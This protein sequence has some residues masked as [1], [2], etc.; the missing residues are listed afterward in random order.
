MPPA[1]GALIIPHRDVLEQGSG[2]VTVVTP[3]FLCVPSCFPCCWYLKAINVVSFRQ[4]VKHKDG[5]FLNIFEEN[6]F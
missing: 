1:M 3:I 6:N 4:G 2:M 5:F